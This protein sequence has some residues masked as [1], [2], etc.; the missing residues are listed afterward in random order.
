MLFTPLEVKYMKQP[1]IV[2][3]FSDWL[4]KLLS[5]AIAY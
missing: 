3:N 5:L 1:T 4:P 2:N